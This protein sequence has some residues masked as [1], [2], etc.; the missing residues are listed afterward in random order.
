MKT[1]EMVFGGL[2]FMW[3]AYHLGDLA[4]HRIFYSYFQG[5]H[6]RKLVRRIEQQVTISGQDRS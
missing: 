5:V 3:I 2:L 1:L 6:D 4:L